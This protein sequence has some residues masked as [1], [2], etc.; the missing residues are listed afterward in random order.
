[1][2]RLFWYAR[3]NAFAAEGAYE[4]QRPSEATHC[5]VYTGTADDDEDDDVEDDEDDE[6][7]EADVVLPI[8]RDALLLT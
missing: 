6:D 7:D 2:E 1:M 8:W 4:C 3:S 5:Q